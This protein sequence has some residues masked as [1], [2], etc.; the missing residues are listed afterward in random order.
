MQTS[1]KEIN[2]QSNIMDDKTII[3][4]RMKEIEQAY[5][6]TFFPKRYLSDVEYIKLKHKLRDI[7]NP[8]EEKVIE[9]K[10]EQKINLI[11]SDLYKKD[12]QEFFDELPSEAKKVLID[13]NYDIFLDKD[14]ILSFYP[15]P[16]TFLSEK[17]MKIRLKHIKSFKR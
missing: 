17:V 16:E 14:N 5:K 12:K 7:T 2:G 8:I 11:N 9:E 10:K 1:N 3:K 13:A 15:K 4:K 6:N